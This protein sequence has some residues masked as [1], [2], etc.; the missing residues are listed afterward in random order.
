M[1]TRTVVSACTA[2]LLLAAAVAGCSDDSKPIP[3]PPTTVVSVT[4]PP[5]PP[6]L[7]GAVVEGVAGKTTTTKV[8]LTPGSASLSGQVLGPDGPVAGASVRVERIVGDAIGTMDVTTAADGTWQA[9]PPP[10]LPAPPDPNAPPTIATTTTR[11]STPQGLVGGR[12]RVRAWRSPDLSLTAPTILFLGAAEQKQLPLQVSRYSGLAVTS[13]VAPSPPIVG[14][15]ANLAVLVTT[16]SV[17]TNGVVRALGVPAAA[18]SLAGGAGWQLVRSDSETDGSGTAFVQ[19]RCR[20]EGP[21]PLAVNVE[22]TASFTLTIAAC[23]L[24]PPSTT[25]SIDPAAE[26]TTTEVPGSSSTTGRTSST[27][28]RQSTT[29][30]PTIGP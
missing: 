5:D 30:A 2:V 22:G 27:T 8:V 21:Q 12:Y 7:A 17:D 28:T 1:R 23:A 4:S 18:V 9:P 13:S 16:R 11:P 10:L 3:E 25:S 6:D 20:Q 26:T 29:T 24:P 15:L 14:E 19:L